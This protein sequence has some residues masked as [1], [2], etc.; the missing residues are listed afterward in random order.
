MKE[1]EFSPQM[2]IVYVTSSTGYR[3]WNDQTKGDNSGDSRKSFS[4]ILSTGLTF[5]TE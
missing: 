2:H 1:D 4:S 3:T 5:I